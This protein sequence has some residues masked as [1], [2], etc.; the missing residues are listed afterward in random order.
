MLCILRLLWFLP[1]HLSNGVD[2]AYTCFTRFQR[3]AEVLASLN[4]PISAGWK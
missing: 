1:M 2:Y 3:E 4:H